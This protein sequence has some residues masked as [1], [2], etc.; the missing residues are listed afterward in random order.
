MPEKIWYNDVL[1]NEFNCLLSIPPVYGG[2]LQQR[3]AWQA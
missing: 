3:L 2:R 1:L